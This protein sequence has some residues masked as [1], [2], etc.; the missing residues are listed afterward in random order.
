MAI[1]DSQIP[2][3]I[4]SRT[5]LSSSNQTA[6]KDLNKPK[7]FAHALATL[8]LALPVLAAASVVPRGDNQCNTG[9][10]QCCDSVQK[11]SDL[12]VQPHSMNSD[13]RFIKGHP[14][15]RFHT[16]RTSWN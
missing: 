15:G 10:I 9:P 11:V 12:S 3:G 7:M 6:F 1:K 4:L 2:S 13:G 8:V 5:N 16:F 14:A